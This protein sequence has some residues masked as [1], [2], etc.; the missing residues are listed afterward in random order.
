MRK[1]YIA[2]LLV[3][4]LVACN[5]MEHTNVPMVTLSHEN[6]LTLSVSPDLKYKKAQDGFII[7]PEGGLDRRSP[8]QVTISYIQGKTPEGDWQSKSIGGSTVYYRQTSQSGG[9]G[10]TEYELEAWKDCIGGYIRTE[11]TVQLEYGDPDFSLTWQVISNAD[12][13]GL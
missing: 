1:N 4:L 10:G 8:I 3:L 2:L 11:Q 9:S 12:R 6:G 5:K 7:Y 13:K